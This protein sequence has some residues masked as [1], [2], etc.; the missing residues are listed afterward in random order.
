VARMKAKLAALTAA[1]R[2]VGAQVAVYKGGQLVCDVTGG[3]LSTIDDRPVESGTHFPLMGAL[4]AV[5]ALA[6]LR[7]L[8]RRARRLSQA[9]APADEG[10]PSA[11]AAA[12]ATAL[13]TPIVRIWPEFSGG[14]SELTLADVLGHCAG[15]QD[16]F[17]TNFGP[18]TLDDVAA[19]AQHLENAD[20]SAAREPRYAYLMQ[21]FV[22]AKLGDCLADEDNLLHWLG[23]ELGDFGLDIAAPAGRGGEAS[24]CR[25]LPQLSRVSM[26][27]VSEGRERRT[28]RT[29][30]RPSSGLETQSLLQ[31]LAKNPLAFDPL[32]GNTEH[33]AKF[34]GGMSLGASACG[35]AELFSRPEVHEDLGALRALEL[36]GED[37]TAIGWL[38]AGGACEAIKQFLGQH[39]GPSTDTRTSVNLGVDDGAGQ[40][41]R[42]GGRGK[43]A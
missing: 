1:Q 33:G 34:R 29:G 25:D 3:T 27:E 41:R 7:A 17:P 39:G 10:S 5:S 37:P 13:H 14:E 2:I 20:L 36:A 11:A 19:V 16:A 4:G 24:I 23:R 31:A 43:K 15:L 8:R 18:S 32:Q 40:A 38:L 12:D 35:L 26:Q 9:A 6:L 42:T 30:S 21:N 28:T 22:M